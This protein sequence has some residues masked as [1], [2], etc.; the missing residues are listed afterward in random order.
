MNMSCFLPKFH[1]SYP[2]DFGSFLTFFSTFVTI[3]II[4]LSCAFNSLDILE[5]LF[6]G[7]PEQ[8]ALALQIQKEENEEA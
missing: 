2:L 4:L 5:C 3:K 1:L 7:Q 6:Y 8:V